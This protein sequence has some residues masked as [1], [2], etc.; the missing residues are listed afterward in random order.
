MSKFKLGDRIV[1][2]FDRQ[3]G[4][5]GYLV[6]DAGTITRIKGDFLKVAWD[7][8]RPLQNEAGEFYIADDRCKLTAQSEV[9]SVGVVTW[10]RPKADNNIINSAVRVLAKVGTTISNVA[11][12][13]YN[14]LRGVK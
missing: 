14:Y 7:I 10:V 1:A 3:C 4:G 12:K 2:T 9:W 13:V 11:V 8:R 5:T 6:G